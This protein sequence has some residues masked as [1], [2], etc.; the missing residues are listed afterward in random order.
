ML[1]YWKLHK[2]PLLLVLGSC[3]FYVFFAYTLDR[4][5]FIKLF[6]LYGAIFFLYIKLIQFERWNTSFLWVAG[7]VFRLIFLFAIP[8][9]SQDF[10]RFIWDG[11]LILNGINPYSYTPNELLDRTPLS[12]P[13][14]HTLHE[15]M[16]ALSAKHY[17]NYP[18]VNQFIFALS[19]WLGMGNITATVITMRLSIILADLGIVFFGRKLLRQLNL[20][21]NL[22]FWYFLNPLVIIELSGNLHFEGVMLFLFIWALYLI[23]TGKYLWA[24]PIYAASILLKLVPLL[25]LPLFLPL[26]GVKRSLFF[27]GVIGGSGLLLLSPFYSPE[28]LENYA[29]T[30]GLWF[31]NFEFNASFYNVIKQLGITYFEAKPWELIKDYGLLLK[32]YLALL[33]IMVTFFRPNRTLGEV[34]RSM[35]LILSCYYFFS[36]TVH[37]W[38]LIF[39]V[40]LSLFSMYRFT[41]IWTGTVVFSY[42]AYSQAD[43]K[44]NLWLIFIEYSLVFA[45]ICYE[46]VKNKDHKVLIRQKWMKV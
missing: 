25:F 29:Q 1:S 15:G 21:P 46:F 40:V 16:G 33:I 13:N 5:D 18:P 9:L 11:E 23:S 2:V 43:F 39:L 31:S 22:I 28:L 44:E 10:Y 4:A 24:A 17:S 34:L 27:Y 41:L 37:P 30:V 38:Y 26:L 42:F 32:L 3:L 19:S 35:L 36:A 45:F 6:C 8:N 20:S 12:I 14:A 7:T